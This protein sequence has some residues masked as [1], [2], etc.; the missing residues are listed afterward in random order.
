MQPLGVGV[1]GC[2]DIAR[3][4]VL[5][6]VKQLDSLKL[7]AVASRTLDKAQ[8]YAAMFDCE[9]VEGY[10]HL[11]ER[12]D[13][14]VIYMPLPTGLHEIWIERCLKAGKHVLV[15]KSLAINYASA[16]K[17]I[18]QAKACQR[19]VME[20]FMF[21]HH[22]QHTYIKN[23]I[24]NGEIGT[25]RVLKSS[26]GFPPLDA[27]NFRYNA[28]LGGGAL[29]DAGAYTVKVAQFFLGANLNV[30]GAQLF[31]DPARQVDTYGAAMLVNQQQQ[32]AQLSFGFDHFYQ[33][34]YS[35]W[36]SQGKISLDR[37]FT[38]P[39]DMQPCVLLEKQGATQTITLSAEDHFI[40][41]LDVLVAAIHNQSLY[42][43]YW[44]AILNQARLLDAIRTG[45]A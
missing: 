36:G 38:T 34:R 12:R 14:D 15:E 42:Q 39:A 29:L 26:F 3:R 30:A 44:D 4:K 41:I 25:I 1:M 21:E 2:A 43:H 6:A 40:R 45:A 7:V 5:P 27:A 20:N 9:A 35:I 31:Y 28:E 8:N 33:C 32:V 17:I 22:S 23:L 18:A 24:Q 10:A 11:L 19:L 13:I 16:Q 37:A